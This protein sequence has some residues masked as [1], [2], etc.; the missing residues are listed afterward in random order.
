MKK[1]RVAAFVVALIA[2]SIVQVAVADDDYYGICRK[3]PRWQGGH[4]DDRRPLRG[5]DRRHGSR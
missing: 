1:N 2:S 3:P 5:S 4:M